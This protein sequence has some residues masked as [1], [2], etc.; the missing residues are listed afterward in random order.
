MVELSRL[1]DARPGGRIALRILTGALLAGSVF[2]LATPPIRAQGWEGAAAVGLRVTDEDGQPIA[3][4]QVVAR[5]SDADDLGPPPVV[6]DAGG[7]AVVSGL[8]DG[9]W[10]IEVS[11]PGYML[12]AAYVNLRAGKKPVVGFSSQVNTATSWSPMTVKF[13]KATADFRPSAPQ[14][15]EPKQPTVV[16]ETPPPPRQPSTIVRPEPEPPKVVRP[17]PQAEEQSEATPPEETEVKATEAPEAPSTAEP[18]PAAGMP[19]DVEAPAVEPESAIPEEST[20]RP[21]PEPTVEQS[22]PVPF[23]PEPVP[24]IETQG[25]PLPEA[26]L[27]E[28]RS[29][30]PEAVEPEAAE[31]ATTPPAPIL[32]EPAPPV[33]V[34]S[35]PAEVTPESPEP[36][37]PE[38]VEP[39]PIEPEPIAPVEAAPE[40]VAPESTEPEPIAPEPVA[41]ESVD[42]A[43]AE[44]EPQPPL[45]EEA[46]P[47]EEPAVEPV[48]SSTAPEEPMIESPA[49][50]PVAPTPERTITPAEP[51]PAE[52]A[53]ATAS[54]MPRFLR[55]AAAGTCSECQPGEWAVAAEQ[56][57]ARAGDTPATSACTDEYLA[58]AR[59]AAQQLADA[60]G[61]RLEGY[62]GP[63]LTAMF[64]L[65][66]GASRDE[67]QE[68]LGAVTDP[69]SNCQMAGIVLP[70]GTTFSGY[71]LEAWDNLGGR[72]CRAG[73]TCAVGQA[74]WLDEPEVVVGSERS[75]V[76]SIFKNRSTRR[77]RR[78][79]MTIYFTPDSEDWAPR[80]R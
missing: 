18:Q 35:Q 74:R 58:T 39:E 6:T 31:P 5:I 20:P 40:T 54:R 63:T 15:A 2:H 80:T 3:D 41:P 49:A 37:V 75:V 42:L 27:P 28:A 52:T 25:G 8:R 51:E 60:P 50:E 34:E 10:F 55:S 79:R 70:R 30:E 57:S 24:T 23:T 16:R 66:D 56:E 21:E 61:E 46:E 33:P 1:F 44:A 29:V 11:H 19:E 65:S 78:L 59:Q 36:V 62:A 7:R 13:Q 64:R 69:E 14:R 73:M 45:P 72:G 53:S 12:F 68:R 76:Y 38:P 67:I 17:E 47:T 4:A 26:S 48:V 43:P 32:P 9:E 71:V 22:E 77:P